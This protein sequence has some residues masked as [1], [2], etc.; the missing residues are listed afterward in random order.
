MINIRNEAG[1]RGSSPSIRAPSISLH[2]LQ[3]SSWL[4]PSLHCGP[5]T[6]A[7][8]STATKR[9]SSQAT[10][11]L[12]LIQR[13]AWHLHKMDAG[14][15]LSSPFPFYEPALHGLGYDIYDSDQNMSLTQ[16]DFMA[17]LPTPT[18]DDHFDL[19]PST[20]PSQSP[21]PRYWKPSLNAPTGREG[22]T[23]YLDLDDFESAE[24]ILDPYNDQVDCET[25]FNSLQESVH[26][27]SQQV[28][29]TQPEY[30]DTIPRS[31]L[32]KKACVKLLFKAWK[33]TA[34]ATDNIGMK[35]PF[36][37]E[38]HDNA[39]VECLCWMLLEALI[40]RSELGPLLVAYDPT[41]SKENP[42]ID[43]FAMRLDEVVISLREQKTICKHLLDAPYINTF[44]DDPVRARNRVASNRDL[45]KKKGDTMSLGR[46]QLH[47]E[48][49]PGTHKRKGM[50]RTRSQSTDGEF[51]DENSL[52]YS[53]SPAL[54]YRVPGRSAYGSRGRSNTGTGS[55]S[56]HTPAS[57]TSGYGGSALYTSPRVSLPMNP[58]VPP[59]SY[60][61]SPTPNRRL[62]RHNNHSSSS[63]SVAQSPSSTSLEL[64]Q[65]I[66]DNYNSMMGQA[67]PSLWMYPTP[68]MAYPDLSR[69]GAQVSGSTVRSLSLVVTK[70]I[71]SSLS[72]S[73]QVLRPLLHLSLPTLYPDRWTR[74]LLS[75]TMTAWSLLE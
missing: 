48:D 58:R 9:F 38:R 6:A 28:A 74:N 12:A 18:M 63:R 39:R 54:P 16:D 40:R 56:Q 45:N 44:V 24:D 69:V 7:H 68:T 5:P 11:S 62:M 71:S 72:H 65:A 26:W 47:R 37:E 10:Q 21:Q 3:A 67:L 73:S 19:A 61:T 1:A 55:S 15:F 8:H 60:Q 42:A 75:L 64:S 30:D 31:L 46:K 52:V 51:S 49:E 32:A 34:S 25:L 57:I 70:N 27:R 13:Y 35:K 43:S 33:S 66:L 36:E 59:L 53:Q 23:P 14:D 4:P 2:F 29:E 22:Q 50:K 17:G 20:P 41:K